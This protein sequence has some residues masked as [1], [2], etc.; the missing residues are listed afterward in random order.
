MATSSNPHQDKPGH[1]NHSDPNLG[2]FS[3]LF[4]ALERPRWPQ[5]FW[6]GLYLT[7]GFV[8]WPFI[9][10]FYFPS[11][12]TVQFLKFWMWTKV[13]LHCI[14]LSSLSS[15]EG[16]TQ[17]WLSASVF[18][19]KLVPGKLGYTWHF[20]SA[21]AK[22]RLQEGDRNSTELGMEESMRFPEIGTLCQQVAL[23]SLQWSHWRPE[24]RV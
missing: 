1:S 18:R 9:S 5:C 2:R 19:A 4:N 20:S 13:R 17:H 12:C 22:F 7:L 21:E 23:Y 10:I 6:L 15:D 11:S 14:F 8:P 3:K 24:V 16:A